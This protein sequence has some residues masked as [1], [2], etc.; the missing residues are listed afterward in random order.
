MSSLVPA[1]ILIALALFHPPFSFVYSEN[2][3]EFG[4]RNDCLFFTLC[5]LLWCQSNDTFPPPRFFSAITL[6][7]CYYFFH[8]NLSLLLVSLVRKENKWLL[9]KAIL[10]A[11]GINK[12]LELY[13][14]TMSWTNFSIT[15]FMKLFIPIYFQHKTHKRL[16][17]CPSLWIGGSCGH[18]TAIHRPIWRQ[19]TKIVGTSKSWN[20]G[21]AYELLKILNLK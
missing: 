8:P 20:G 14:V 12:L 17:H 6:P 7:I 21:F 4:P 5:I 18:Q 10:I 19:S 1:Y 2:L 13:Y 15:I 9:E 11:L 3:E 16:I